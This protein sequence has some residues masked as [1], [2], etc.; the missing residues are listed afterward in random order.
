MK[1]ERITVKELNR[2]YPVIISLGSTSSFDNA[3]NVAYGAKFYHAGGLGW[4]YDVFEI[5]TNTC[6]VSGYRVSDTLKTTGKKYYAYTD[7]E[8]YADKL[9][10]ITEKYRYTVGMKAHK[11]KCNA[12]KKIIENFV[13]AILDSAKIERGTKK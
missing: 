4:N 3:L 8:L 2:I 13:S 12:Y 7:C 5:D 11:A 6:I 9:N 10:A 1:N